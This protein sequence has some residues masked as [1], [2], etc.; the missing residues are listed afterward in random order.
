[1]DSCY[2]GDHTTRDRTHMDITIL[3]TEEPQ[4]KY[5][6]G[7]VNKILLG[8]L[9]TFILYIVFLPL[10][11]H[12]LFLKWQKATVSHESFSFKIKL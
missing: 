5:R 6:L 3:N 2:T 4:Q 1:M 8:S 10:F 9:K 7:T 12:N 11:I